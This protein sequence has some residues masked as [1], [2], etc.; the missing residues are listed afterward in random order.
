MN[1]DRKVHTAAAAAAPGLFYLL[2]VA[3]LTGCTSPA[4][5]MT[6]HGPQAYYQTAHPTHDTSKELREIIRSV[7]RIQVTGYYTTYVFMK[8]EQITESD[9][10]DRQTFNRALNRV[11]FNHSKAGTATVISS[12]IHSTVLITNEHVVDYPDTLIQY[13]TED[14]PRSRRRGAP[15]YIESVSIKQNQINLVFDLPDIRSFA[16]LSRDRRHDLAL[17]GIKNSPNTVAPV[18]PVIR[19][20]SG[21]PSQL[22]W[23]SFTYVLG[24][25]KGF[26]MVSRAIVSDPNRDRQ[27]SFLLDALFNRGISGGIVLAVRSDGPTLEWVGMARAASATSE[28]ILVPE[29]RDI[30]EF[31]VILPYDGDI[32]VENVQRVDYGI[33]FPIPMT[34]IQRFIDENKDLLARLGYAVRGHIMNP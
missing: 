5:V 3:G 6:D 12:D 2:V 32:Y 24:Y 34:V 10:R 25:P 9:L 18:P 13:Y 26:P 15:R 27:S 23:G 7:K 21:D 1:L 8:E 30:G 14:A 28:L 22:V 4:Y 33:T 16:V 31:G 17:I 19:T 29:R 20:K 11:P